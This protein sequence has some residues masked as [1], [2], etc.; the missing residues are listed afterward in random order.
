MRRE[1]ELHELKTSICLLSGGLDSIVAATMAVQQTT[2]LLCITF[3]YGQR[4]GKQEIESADKVCK[5]LG[6]PHRVITLDWLGQTSSAILQKERQTGTSLT[7]VLPSV[8]TTKKE[9]RDVPEFS[10]EK[11]DPIQTAKAV[12][13]PNRNGVF[14]NIAASLA[15]EMDVNIIVVGFN[16]EEAETF[17]DNSLEFVQAINQSLSFSTLHK[18]Q[19]MSF[20][21]KMNKK[22]IV[23]LGKQISAPFH[24]LWSCYLGE[25]KMCGKCESCQRCIRAFKLAGSFEMIKPLLSI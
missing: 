16:R 12:W 7:E 24:L 19:V 5:Y 20:T 18:V 14:I 9:E 22:E 4:A 6:I 3:D 21:Q 10:F 8:S 15:E 2:V 17:P 13:V 11:S 23:E 1:H 25:D